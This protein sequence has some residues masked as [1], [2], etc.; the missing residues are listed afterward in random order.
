MSWSGRLLV[1]TPAL[2][3]P[4]FART[5]VLLLQHG[6]Q[7]GALGVVVN[8]PSGTALGEVLPAW[9]PLAAE[10]DLV[11]TGGPVQ[12]EAAICLGLRL[13]GAPG[14]P[15]VAA[16]PGD[17]A[18]ATV[19]LDASPDDLAPGLQAV[20]VFA[21]YAGWSPGQLEDEVAQGGWWVLDGLPGDAFS[22]SPEALWRQVLRR[23]GMPLALVATAPEDPTLN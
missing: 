8:R 23:Q 9:S 11:F 13:P 22:T 17:P 1:A 4:T 20:R 10:P 18:L 16:L 15:A 14:G 6:A 12:P 7:E 2:T 19:D 5:V 3:E 21:G